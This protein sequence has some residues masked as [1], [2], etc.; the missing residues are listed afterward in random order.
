MFL[1]RFFGL[2]KEVPSFSYQASLKG[3]LGALEHAMYELGGK[4]L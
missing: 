3:G 2:N 4:K 1:G